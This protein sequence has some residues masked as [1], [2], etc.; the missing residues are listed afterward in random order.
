MTLQEA[1]AILK[2]LGIKSTGKT[3]NLIIKLEVKPESFDA[4]SDNFDELRL[5]GF[6]VAVF[7]MTHTFYNLSPKHPKEMR[8]CTSCYL[9]IDRAK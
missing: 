3:A 9:Y 6:R 4:V 8:Q 1:K 7:G 2:N 5:L